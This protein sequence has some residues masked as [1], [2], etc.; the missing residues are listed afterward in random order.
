[1]S[2]GDD[3]SEGESS[4]KF[5]AGKYSFTRGKW[6]NI[7]TSPKGFF[8]DSGKGMEASICSREMPARNIVSER[9]EAELLEGK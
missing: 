6:A 1:M 8:P 2:I 3:S 5:G 9:E 4:N 7:Q